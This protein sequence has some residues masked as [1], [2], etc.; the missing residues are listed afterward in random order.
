MIELNMK[1]VDKLLCNWLVFWCWSRSVIGG[2]LMLLLVLN[3]FEKKFVI[4]IW[5]GFGLMCS[6][7]KFI[8]IVNSINKLSYSV[9]VCVE[10]YISSKLFIIDFGMCLIKVIF[11]LLIEIFL[12]CFIVLSIEINSVIK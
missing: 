6:G 4:F 12:W 11:K 3:M 1:K 9:S 7:S 2:L 5:V 10:I 8:V